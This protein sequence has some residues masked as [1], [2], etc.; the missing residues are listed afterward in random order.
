MEFVYLDRR[1]AVC[2]KPAGVLSTDEPGGMPELV[3]LALGE[4]E[5]CVRTVH[6]LDRPVGGLMV[7]ARSRRAASE[8]SRQIR[9]GQFQKEYLAVVHG[10]PEPLRGR[11]EDYLTRDSRSHR[12][13]I[14]AGPGPDARPAALNYEMLSAAGELSLVRIELLTGRTHQIRCQFAGRGM[15]LAGDGKY[16][17]PEDGYDIALWSH[18]LRFIHP[19]SGEEMTFIQQPPDIYPFSLFNAGKT[20]EE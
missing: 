12:T 10:R 18:K 7:L 6:R 8:L 19:E 1:I 17:L 11:M 9:E 2:V 15:P 20:V 4:P 16:G 5:G 14:A 3:R 13:V